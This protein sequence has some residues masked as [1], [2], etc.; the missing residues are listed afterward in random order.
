MRHGPVRLASLHRFE[1][2]G[3]AVRPAEPVLGRILAAAGRTLQIANVVLLHHLARRLIRPLVELEPSRARLGGQIIAAVPAHA[4]DTHPL[5]RGPAIWCV[6]LLPR[7]DRR[8][9]EAAGL[10]EIA[11]E[12]RGDRA[13]LLH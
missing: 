12:A 6:P 10:E 3:D 11:L 2:Q 4:L 1:R 13:A 7:R 5:E 9:D 8:R